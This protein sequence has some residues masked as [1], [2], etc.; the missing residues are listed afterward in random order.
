MSRLKL[1][2]F[3]NLRKLLSFSFYDFVVAT[4]EDDRKSY[5]AYLNE[6]YAAARVRA[7]L[8][9]IADIIDAEV[10]ASSEQDYDPYGASAL[11]LLSDEAGSGAAPAWAS[12][13]R[14]HLDKSHIAAHTYPDFAHPEGILGFRVDIELST[15]GEISPLRSLDEI[16]RFFD[17][18]VVVIDYLVRGYTRAED[19]SH[20]FMDHEV[21]SIARFI[22]P[23]ILAQFERVERALPAAHTWQLKLLR[24]RIDPAEYFAPG[25]P[26]DEVQLQGVLD[27]MAAVYRGL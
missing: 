2:G 10:L 3:N 26:V 13:V 12:S 4:D 5:A 27:E 24:T 6:R 22:D 16:F 23:E 11:L 8:E 20:V 9:R 25:K 21:P 7:L 18:D 1:S 19:G 17:T 14:M 15:C